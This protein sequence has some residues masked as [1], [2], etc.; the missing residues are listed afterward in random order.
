MSPAAALLPHS[1]H[2]NKQALSTFNLSIS[3]PAGHQ[4]LAPHTPT[5]IC[6]SATTP[7]QPSCAATLVVRA[8]PPLE[9]QQAVNTGPSK[10]LEASSTTLMHHIFGGKLRS[11][12]R[13]AQTAC[14]EAGWGCL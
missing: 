6:S 8:A 13:A 7:T 5:R 1:V 12:V 14:K 4:H 11:Q 10:P 2:T 9:R 3:H